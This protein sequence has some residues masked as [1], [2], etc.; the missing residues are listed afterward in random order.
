MSA[1]SWG[2][3]SWGHLE[4]SKFM[5]A[6]NCTYGVFSNFVGKKKSWCTDRGSVIRNGGH[7]TGS[8]IQEDKAKIKGC[9]WETGVFA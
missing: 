6:L 3:S 5:M 8:G 7:R 1:F 2:N 4:T 9:F